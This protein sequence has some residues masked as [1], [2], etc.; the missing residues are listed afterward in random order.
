MNNYF[1]RNPFLSYYIIALLMP[2]LIF[3]YIS[4]YTSWQ[5]SILGPDYNPF[6]QFSQ[7]LEGIRAEYPRL[8]NHRDSI[9]LYLYGYIQ[10]PAG[11]PFL[12]FPFAPTVSAII[13]TWIGRGKDVLINLLSLYRPCLGNISLRDGLKIYAK[14]LAFLTTIATFMVLREH[15][16]GDANVVDKYLVHL[17]LID[18]KYFLITTF[19]A[20]LFNQGALLEELGWRGYALPLLIKK[21]G[22]PLKASIL[23]GIAWGLWHLPREAMTLLSGEQTFYHFL[24]GQFIFLL[25]TMS[26]SVVATYFVNI[27]GGSVIPAIMIHGAYNHLGMML[28]TTRISIRSDFNMMP[29][30][31]WLLGAVVVFVLGGSDLGWE[32]RKSVHLGNINTDPS[33]GWTND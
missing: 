32:K 4:I 24:I 17:G 30:Y 3:V 26:M 14:L 11:F 25:S 9:I 7:I 2:S 29:A 33:K 12:F 20:L 21:I 23:L 27:T 22:S 18:W 13:V 19:V 8:F 15:F 31:F 6:V 16:F 5:Q 28:N 1:R 10:M